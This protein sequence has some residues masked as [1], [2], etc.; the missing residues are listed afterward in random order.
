[1]ADALDRGSSPIA[2]EREE[3]GGRDGD[4]GVAPRV[5]LNADEAAVVA[6]AGVGGVGFVEAFREGQHAATLR[7]TLPEF[8]ATRARQLW[9]DAKD[10]GGHEC[11]LLVYPKGDTAALPGYSSVFLEM[12]AKAPA[13]RADSGG[14]GRGAPGNWEC[15]AWYA[16]T[17]VHP[18]DPTKNRTRQSYHR[19]SATKKSHGWC[20]FAVIDPEFLLDGVVL[21][22][23]DIVVLS[24][25]AELSRDDLP[26]GNPHLNEAMSEV[27]SG[28]FQWTIHNFN[29]F[30]AMMGTHKIVSPKFPAGDCHFAVAAY[31]TALGGEDGGSDG[32]GGLSAEPSAWLL[33]RVSLVNQVD[34]KKTAHRDT[35]GR[36]AS[37]EDGGDHTSL[38]WNDF[39]DMSRL[40]DPEEGFS[41][42]AAGKVTLA[43]T[44]YVI[45]ESHGARGSRHGHGGVDGDGAYRARFVWK[46]D[47]FTKLKDLLKKRKMNGLC[48]KSKRFV[49]GGK[50]C[51]VVIYPRGQ[52]SPATSLSMFLEVTNVSERRRRPPTA[53]K[54]N[55]SVFVSHRMGVL[56]HHDASKSV[57]RESQ[58]R[59][60]RSAKDWGWREFL[61]LTSLFDNDAGF[62]DPA[63]DRVVF[64]AEVL[65]LKEHSELKKMDPTRVA[66][67]IMS[68]EDTLAGDKLLWGLGG[69]FGKNMKTISKHFGER[70]AVCAKH[71]T[72]RCEEWWEGTLQLSKNDRVIVLK[73]AAR[74]NDEID[75]LNDVDAHDDG[76]SDHTLE[77]RFDADDVVNVRRLTAE[78]DGD[79]LDGADDAVSK[80]RT[81]PADAP[82]RGVNVDF[83]WKIENVSAFRGILET[84]KLFSRFFPA[85]GVNLR[86]G[87]YESFDTLCVYL[88][89][90]QGSTPSAMKNKTTPPGGG[91]GGAIGEGGK[92][93]TGGGDGGGGGDG[94]GDYWVRYRVAVTNQKHPDRTKWK[95]ATTSSKRWTSNVIQFMPTEDLTHPE[96]GY[97]VKDS[98][99]LAVEV[100]DV[101]YFNPDVDDGGSGFS[102]GDVAGAASMLPAIMKAAM[103]ENAAEALSASLLDLGMSGADVKDTFR[104]AAEHFNLDD[105]D[106]DELLHAVATSAAAAAGGGGGSIPGGGG[107]AA[108]GKDA[109]TKRLVD[110]LGPRGAL[111]AA[112]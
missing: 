62:L 7:W 48:V 24:E 79:L 18:T 14:K 93:G 83:T 65:V 13:A 103:N 61:P 98:I 55:W 108:A 71:P 81:P 77:K 89:S 58:N 17:V 6:A 26:P 47:N 92:I 20:D 94:D 109:A 85:G 105:C 66:G 56:N 51:R 101:C 97:L 99:A 32:G 16:L 12:R 54:H 30:R 21:V 1:M 75:D 33:F 42:G 40:D 49:V 112:A 90:D 86:L 34:S 44:F 91:G 87:A 76:L 22:C 43:V 45:R 88:E 107:V 60:G 82:G 11:R 10:V 69:S 35:Y 59:Y 70:V 8:G 95:D 102:K 80:L 4:D 29:A 41:T 57:I 110:K 23:A 73:Y 53:G 9:G 3:G 111:A 39:L 38:G 74:W 5:A 64:V 36:F 46:I 100:L 106:V 2:H 78:E 96:G 72:T 19:F 68:F 84:R 63:R 25:T 104:T 37:G 15:F 28:R 27:T 31:Q 52:Q 50:D 67:A